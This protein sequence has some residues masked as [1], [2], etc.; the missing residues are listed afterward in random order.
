MNAFD[1]FD[2][3]N[4]FDRFDEKPEQDRSVPE[5]SFS[6]IFT[7]DDRATEKTD[8]LP[9]ISNIVASLTSDKGGLL[10]GEDGWKVAKIIPALMTTLDSEG[11]ANI[12][13]SNFEN[14][15]KTYDKDAQGNP[16]PILVNNKTG[17][18]FAINKP[19]LSGIDL[20][21]GGSLAAAFTPAG[22]AGMTAGGTLG[23]MAK[24]GAASGGTQAGLNA[25]QE[26]QGRNADMQDIAS[27]IGFAGLGGALFE[28]LFRS[29]GAVVKPLF[30]RL[31]QGQIDDT[32]REIITEQAIKLGVDPADVT[33]D[34]IRKAA[35]DAT[36]SFNVNPEALNPLEKEFNVTLTNAQRS[37]NQAALSAEDSLRAG[38]RGGRAQEIFL[39]GEANQ[40]DELARASAGVQDDI[41]RGA[42]TINTRQQAGSALRES[43]RVAEETARAAKD[44]AYA[45]VGEAAL[46]AKSFKDV[47]RSV[48]RSV[49]GVEFDKSLPETAKILDGSKGII[50]AID[51]MG[52]QIKPYHIRQIENYRKRLNTALNSAAPKS[53]DARQIRIMKQQFDDSLDGALLNGLFQGDDTALTT[54]KQA[55]SLNTEYS[56]QFRNPDSKIVQR[57]VESNPTDEE[58]INS[59]FTASGFN[60]AG[61]ANL[62]KSYKQILGADSEAWNMVRQAAFKQ[63]VRTN[64]DGVISGAKTATAIA[65]ASEQNKSLLME[66]FTPD[67]WAKIRRFSA[68]VKRA[69]PDLVR[70]REN[71]SGTA[72]KLGKEMA[73]NLLPWLND[74]VLFATAGTWKMAKNRAATTA[75]KNAFR[76]FEQ[77]SRGA[78]Y[79]TLEGGAIGQSER[80]AKAIGD[81]F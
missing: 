38:M 61:A 50:K 72:Q 64:S 57:I 70:S 12:I 18:A 15:G 63:L 68:L 6:D 46:D 37:G 9:E 29:F 56:K 42:E 53:A 7:G 35:N 58:V 73:N 33:D 62:A 47:L 76:P 21:Q 69:Q 13:Q 24:V 55:R 20:L 66:L 34:F 78:A 23:A 74:G 77:A 27:E 81:A 43:V 10:G 2:A 54:L 31:A 49:T 80:T 28:G 17:A 59:L 65:K 40:L 71:P 36:D 48:R 22:R 25:Y 30:K 41:A 52:D 26:S 16:Y 32:S 75:A 60:R 5:S 39:K 44:D 67:E 51:K 4:S 1:Q 79:S 19:G 8:S 45:A 11:I 14:V 3:P